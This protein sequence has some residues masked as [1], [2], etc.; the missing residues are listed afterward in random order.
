MKN[1]EWSEENIETVCKI[2]NLLSLIS[3][4][5]VTPVFMRKNEEGLYVE[6]EEILTDTQP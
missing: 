4:N 2:T 3:G 5:R 1:D 6:D